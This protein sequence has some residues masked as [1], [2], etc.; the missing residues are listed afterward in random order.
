MHREQAE[1]FDMPDMDMDAMAGLH[2]DLFPQ[3]MPDIP[4]LPDMPQAPQVPD[5]NMEAA[6]DTAQQ[7]D[8]E[9]PAMDAGAAENGLAMQG[10]LATAAEHAQ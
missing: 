8:Q 7:V 3:D 9:V 1:T 4:D 5:V 6:D 2:M 10:K